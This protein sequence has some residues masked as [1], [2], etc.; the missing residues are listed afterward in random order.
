MTKIVGL[1]GGI[2]SGKTFV[3]GLFE[4]KGVPVYYTDLEAKK[5]EILICGACVDYYNKKDEINIG[6]ISNMY[7]I[8][9]T[10]TNASHIIYP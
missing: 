4:K 10:L 6:T 8:M 7:D 1:T 5:I 9:N 3:A 2:G